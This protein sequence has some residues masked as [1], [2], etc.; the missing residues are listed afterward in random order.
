[1]AEPGS[2]LATVPFC[3]NHPVL[4]AGA[5]LALCLVPPIRASEKTMRGEP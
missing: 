4:W 3:T 1:M 5:G 2:T